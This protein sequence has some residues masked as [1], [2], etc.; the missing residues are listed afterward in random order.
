MNII[1][2]LIGAMAGALYFIGLWY[3]TRLFASGG[4]TRMAIVVMVS[5]ITLLGGLL[6][7]ASLEGAVPLLTMAL[8]VLTARFAAVRVANAT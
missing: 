1:S 5:R 6:T 4:S 3:N 7:L 2:F 8:G